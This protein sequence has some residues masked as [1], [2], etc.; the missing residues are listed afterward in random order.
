[1]KKCLAVLLTAALLGSLTPLGAVESDG[2]YLSDIPKDK[3]S[4]PNLSF[5]GYEIKYDV[6]GYDKPIHIASE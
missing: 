6:N 4:V 5:D 1:M 3:I 2:L